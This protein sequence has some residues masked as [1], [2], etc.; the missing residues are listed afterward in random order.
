MTN[1]S[2]P[3]PK[4]HL[5]HLTALNKTIVAVLSFGGHAD[6]VVWATNAARLRDLLQVAGYNYDKD[7]C[8][9]VKPNGP[10][11]MK[12]RNNEIWIEIWLRESPRM[13]SYVEH[14]ISA[15]LA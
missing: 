11:Q 6:D 4:D 3:A 2:L 10:F 1:E 7:N 12:T 8:H 15:K 14:V 13:G 5:V 9:L